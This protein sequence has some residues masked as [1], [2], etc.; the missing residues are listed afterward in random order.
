[1]IPPN[2]GD[3]LQVKDLLPV[4]AV[5]ADGDSDAVDLL[6]LSGEIAV[7]LDAASSG[8]AAKTLA[9]KLTECDTSGGSYTDVSGGGFTTVADEA[10]V[11][12]ISLNKDALKR[13]VKLNLNVTTGDTIS[14]LTSAKIVGFNKYPA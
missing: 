4:Q 14:V 6:E 8:D 13:Y 5:T 12:K 7:I 11:Q 10:S 1:M 3:H 2:L 9:C